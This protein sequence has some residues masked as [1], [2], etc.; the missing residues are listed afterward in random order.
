MALAAQIDNLH[1]VAVV[2]DCHAVD[3]VEVKII[4]LPFERVTVNKGCPCHRRSH[5]VTVQVLHVT[6]GDVYRLLV[7]LTVVVEHIDHQFVAVE[8]PVEVELG[9]LAVTVYRRMLN[10]VR[11]AFG[12]RYLVLGNQRNHFVDDLS[13]GLEL[14]PVVRTE[15][16]FDNTVLVLFRLLERQVCHQS[17]LVAER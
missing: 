15:H 9:E 10:L 16:D 6:Y 11:H 14:P 3:V 4:I 13:A 17:H 5:G 1:I 12:F 7:N 2:G 8:R